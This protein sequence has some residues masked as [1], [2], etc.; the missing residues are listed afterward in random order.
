MHAL[1]FTTALR[2]VRGRLG[3]QDMY[4]GGQLDVIK[5]SPAGVYVSNIPLGSENVDTY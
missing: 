3:S 5:P 2:C 4:Q 1:A